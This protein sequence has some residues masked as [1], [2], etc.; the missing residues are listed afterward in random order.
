MAGKIDSV[1]YDAILEKHAQEV[2]DQ[3]AAE[4]A[5]RNAP[6][7]MLSPDQAGSYADANPTPESNPYQNLAAALRQYQQPS[8]AQVGVTPSSAKLG[9]PAQVQGAPE[10][11]TPESNLVMAQQAPE[12]FDAMQGGMAGTGIQAN[13][14]VPM[15]P[16]VPPDQLQP[17]PETA[18]MQVANEALVNKQAELQAAQAQA[19]QEALQA[20]MQHEANIQKAADT[21]VA[22]QDTKASS[23]MDSRL[24]N[25]L[26]QGLAVALGEYGRYLTGGKEN[27]AVGAIDRAV[28]QASDKAHL[29]A[30][31]KIALRKNALDKAH[32]DLEAKIHE[33][34]SDLKKAQIGKIQ[35][36]IKVE[37]Q[38]VL[39]QQKLAALVRSGKGLSAEDLQILPDKDRARAVSLPN[40]SY[41][42]AV[43]PMRAKTAQEAADAAAVGKDSIKRLIEFSD[44]FGNNP[45]KKTLDRENIAEAQNIQKQL[46]GSM[47]TLLVGPGNVS[48]YEH[49]L[50]ESVI[51]DPTA[52]FS[53]SSA[54]KAALT[55]LLHKTQAAE[56]RAYRG[57]GINLPPSQNDINISKLR[58]A[59]PN[60]TEKQAEDLLIKTGKW[61]SE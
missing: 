24:G 56:R 25:A 39:A 18:G 35:A 28:K 2:A 51:R 46:K 17:N 45:L 12:A 34:D 60:M 26:G 49:K 61:V 31:E 57:A 52:I 11:P 40:G 27:L 22:K 43:S 48:T 23:F 13:M 44:Y 58:S 30:D 21:E 42:L 47:R 9:E 50:M 41:G 32:L 37:Q 59:S 38:K 4:E 29:D 14:P 16:A 15:A 8:A 33:T 20:K 36:E 1:D 10:M 53:M 5:A 6:P 54:N 3:S 7:A 55:S 19:Q